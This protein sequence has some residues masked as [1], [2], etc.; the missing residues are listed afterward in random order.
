MSYR[1][2]IDGLRAIAVAAVVLYHAGVPGFGGGYIGV[3]I[4]FVISGYLITLLLVAPSAEPLRRRLVEFYLRRA[5][6]ILPALL[7]VSLLTAA[8]AV[9]VLLPADLQR[10]GR[11][12]A[13]TPVFLSN[14]AAW[15]DGGYFNA[16]LSHVS[17]TH[18][19]SI[20][21]EEQFYLLYPLLLFAVLRFVPRRRVAVLAVFAAASLALC[22]W[23][24]YE[25]PVANYYFAPGRGWELLLGALVALS[26]LRLANNGR[27]AQA[28]AT[29]SLCAIAVAVW[30]YDASLKYPGVYALVPCV[31]A[32]VLLLTGR[33]RPT[34]VHR[35]LALR[36]L[37]FTGLISYS[38]YLLHWPILSL[39]Q[40][41][42]IREPGALASGLLI[43]AIYLAAV[44]SW[45]AIEQ[46]IR[47]RSLL[48]ANRPFV[49]GMAGLSALIF[50]AG[51]VL[52]HSGGWPE[53][54]PAH[55]V[56]LA[57]TRRDLH[58]DIRRCTALPLEKLRSGQ[59]C[60]YGPADRQA[61][62]VVLWGDSHAMALLPAY[63]AL[64]RSRGVRLY[65]AA[66]SACGP[67]LKV[68]DEKRFDAQRISCAQFNEAVV[69][70]IVRI[71]P[72]RVILGGY[73][74]YIGTRLR[75]QPGSQV[76]ADESVFSWGLRNT[77]ER[78]AAPGRVIYAVLDA[79]A[80][81]YPVAYAMAMAQRKGIDDSFIG[82][83]RAQVLAQQ[84]RS[85]EDIREFE[86]RGAIRTIDIKDLL[87]DAALCRFQA[88]GLPLYRDT[89]HLS[90][91]GAAFVAPV[92]ARSLP[93]P[94]APD[95]PFARP[96]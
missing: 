60:S 4:F 49:L 93:P 29:A 12:L 58:P 24:S 92:L 26:P 11:Y 68:V 51:L 77:L 61:P 36:P 66:A 88:G 52:W 40:Y 56:A 1:A 15:R 23:S 85:E 32:A 41:Y 13:A 21:V 62:K 34:F 83:S 45:R 42:E 91:A 44:A 78:I 47:R 53:R 30:N 89:N 59:F 31:A 57:D 55:I 80:L 10:F 79:P 35:F 16:G 90:A 72:Q 73:W 20:A 14:L 84:R 5:R 67:L 75:P 28:L 50:A 37:V 64:A 69:E 9:V 27:A 82:V 39:Y 48:R 19:W 2:D 76:G 6:R 86:S 18:L 70:G 65:F 7:L 22:V 3:D 25:K 38:L 95:A 46:P 43:V 81:E 94:A 71:K 54:L 96:D 87:C 74:T 8:V 17:L 33:S 63:E